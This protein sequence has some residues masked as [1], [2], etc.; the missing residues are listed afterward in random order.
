[1]KDK[2][3]NPITKALEDM[4]MDELLNID[5]E[6]CTSEEIDE[7]LKWMRQREKEFL[8]AVSY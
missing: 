6:S 3:G 5:N 1:M 2:Q 4:T 8:E 7:K